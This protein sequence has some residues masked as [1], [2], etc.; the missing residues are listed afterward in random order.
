LFKQ[1]VNISKEDMEDYNWLMFTHAMEF[2]KNCEIFKKS[3]I[4]LFYK[5]VEQFVDRGFSIP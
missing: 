3:I 4:Y 1:A 2:F 5:L